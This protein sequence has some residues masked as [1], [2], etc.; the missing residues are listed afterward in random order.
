MHTKYKTCVVKR[1]KEKWHNYECITVTMTPW[2]DCCLLR[3]YG[4]KSQY[5]HIQVINLLNQWKDYQFKNK[6]FDFD[7]TKY[8]F[9]SLYIQ[10]DDISAINCKLVFA[11]KVAYIMSLVG[12]RIIKWRQNK[13]WMY[14]AIADSINNNLNKF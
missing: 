11:F 10:T 14:S 9:L 6:T 13:I 1:N 5:L 2:R 3:K 7:T 12:I 4:S 8:N